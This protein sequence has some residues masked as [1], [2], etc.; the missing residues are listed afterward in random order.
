MEINSMVWR[1]AAAAASVPGPATTT[2]PGPTTASED[3]PG[4]R[5][6]FEEA[7]GQPS[8]EAGVPAG[9]IA[10]DHAITAVHPI[11]SD[12]MTPSTGSMDSLGDEILSSIEQAHNAY[13]QNLDKI[14]QEVGE[15]T[16]LGHLMQLQFDVIKFGLDQ[17]LTTKIADKTTQGVET[18]LKNQG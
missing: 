3:Q 18:V 8:V 17:D 12:D 11:V 1:T 14:N 10:P 9:S 15:P 6:R 2:T 4:D 5:E 13:E 16:S 7:L